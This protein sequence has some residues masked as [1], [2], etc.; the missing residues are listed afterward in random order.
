[1]FVINSKLSLTVPL[2]TTVAACGG[3]GGPP[4]VDETNTLNLAGEEKMPTIA[5]FLNSGD[6]EA[7]FVPVYTVKRDG[8]TTEFNNY[9]PNDDV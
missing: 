1:M 2:I 9:R 3:G 5:E 8:I 7:F 4:P 6:N